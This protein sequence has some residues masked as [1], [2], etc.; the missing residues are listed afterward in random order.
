MKF[1]DDQGRLI[2][3]FQQ[4]TQ[5]ADEHLIPMNVP[6]WGGWPNLSGQGAAE[7]AN[8]LLDR[9]VK[10]GDYCA[11]GGQ[12]HVDPFQVGGDP[13]QKESTFLEGTLDHARELGVPI[14]S[15]QEWLHFSALRHDANL[16]EVVWDANAATLAFQLAPG[17]T[18]HAPSSGQ[19]ESTVTMLLPLRHAGK[20]LTDLSVDGMGVPL[21]SSLIL[22]NAEYALVIVSATGHM[23]KATYA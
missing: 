23:F 10:A 19:P 1:I 12:F 5:I 22:G 2:D 15:A 16:T 17:T 7:V 9:S 13:A 21:T 6:G 3:L 14:W 11:I 4:L 20:A 8:Y 18:D